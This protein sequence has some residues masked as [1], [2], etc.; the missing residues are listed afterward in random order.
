MS[1]C[2][3][4]R[5]IRDYAL[6]NL[7]V[8]NVLRVNN[9]LKS[10]KVELKTLCNDVDNLFNPSTTQTLIGSFSCSPGAIIGLNYNWFYPSGRNQFTI[11]EISSTTSP[12]SFEKLIYTSQELIIE[13][14]RMAASGEYKTATSDETPFDLTL[15]VSTFPG[16]STQ[17]NFS[18]NGTPVESLSLKNV[19]AL[20]SAT[21]ALSPSGKIPANSY[22]GIR[23]TTN[24]SPSQSYISVYKFK[25]SWSLRVRD[26]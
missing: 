17:S 26:V 10:T 23:M 3:L 4:G 5:P 25:L 20:P 18:S 8:N 24:I 11:S 12:I 2:D 1:K 14:F 21:F 22:F 15:S 19:T 13:D 16:T 9:L 6:D 7:S